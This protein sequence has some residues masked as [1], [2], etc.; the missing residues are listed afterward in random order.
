[1]NL[2]RSAVLAFL[3]SGL[4]HGADQ[5]IEPQ[6]VTKN[7]ADSPARVKSGKV[8]ASTDV[9]VPPALGPLPAKVFV[10]VF[11]DFQCPVCR[12]S[13]D[14]T[15]QIAEEFP[16]EVRVEFWQNP[17]AMHQNAENAAVAS[18]AAQRQGKFW[19]YHDEVFRNQAALDAV[20]LARYAEQLG[21]DV[22]RFNADYGAP[23]LRARA[24]AEGAVAEKFGARST[25]AFMVNGKVHIGWGS[26][27]GFRADVE[28]ELAEARRLEAQ[29]TPIEQLADR[30]AQAQIEDPELLRAYR[31]QVLR[32]APEASKKQTKKKKKQ[33][34]Q[35]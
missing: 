18:L 17:L 15:Q 32:V 34:R 21:L 7:P 28:R 29:G 3:V 12:R 31:E 6:P 8:F 14:A 13:A 33:Q 26:W 5:S 35:S 2:R 19:E 22:P 10:I 30:R 4:V 9:D 1:M 20:S 11:S 16:G 27:S 23:E 24:K 25:P